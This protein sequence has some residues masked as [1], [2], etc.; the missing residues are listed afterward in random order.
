M[1]G[2]QKPI[3]IGLVGAGQNTRYKHIPGLLAQEGV[4]LVAVA[5]RRRASSERVARDYGIARVCDHWRQV[6]EADDLDA[7]VIGTWPYLHCPVTLAALAAGKHVLTEARMAMN[8]A[9]AEMMLAASRQAPH[10]VTQIVPGGGSL[11]KDATIRRLIADGYLGDIVAVEVK[12][13]SGFI[14]REAPLHWRHNTEYSGL[15]ISSMGIMYEDVMFWLGPVVHLSALGRTFVSMRTDEHG[16]RR[17]ISI[18]ES[19]RHHRGDGVR[20]AAPHAALGGHRGT[21]HR[22]SRFTAPRRPCGSRA[23]DCSAARAMMR[24]CGPSLS[25]PPGRGR[26]HHTHPAGT[27]KRSSSGR[28]A[29][30]VPSAARGSRT[31]CST[32]R[33]PRPSTAACAKGAR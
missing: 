7:I 14:D 11:H 22:R 12:Q 33:S 26:Q 24:S 19:S 3:R 21:A 15:N 10:L 25:R 27:W 5:N 18:P 20:R 9:E 8:L 13:S 32:W 4:E 29:A 1:A 28:S 2:K 17:A 23:A 6:V 16:V 31:A 30:R